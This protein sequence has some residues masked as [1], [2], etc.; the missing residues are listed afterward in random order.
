M[1]ILYEYVCDEGHSFYSET[2][3]GIGDEFICPICGEG[4]AVRQMDRAALIV[5]DESSV[6]NFIDE[7]CSHN[8]QGFGRHDELRIGTVALVQ[9][10]EHDMAV[11]QR[12]SRG[13]LPTPAKGGES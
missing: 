12:R 2:R 6:G 7:L 11:K 3:S 8:E 13:G 1:M 9:Q 5:A 4:S 10:A